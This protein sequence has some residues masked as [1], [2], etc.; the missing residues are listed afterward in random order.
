[1]ILKRILKDINTYSFTKIKIKHARKSVKN[2][3][4]LEYS[5]YNQNGREALIS[6]AQ[7]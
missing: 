5:N 3:F 1:M 6:R 2:P 7:W 4:K